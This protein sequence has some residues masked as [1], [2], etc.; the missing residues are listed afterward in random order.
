MNTD[1]SIR[2][3]HRGY[4]WWFFFSYFE[5]D[6]L[7]AFK[8]T[9]KAEANVAFSPFGNSYEDLLAKEGTNYNVLYTDYVNYS[10]IYTCNEAWFGTA[11]TELLWFMSRTNMIPE[12]DLTML[13]AK[14]TA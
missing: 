2:V 1:G 6:G 13:K 8:N 12:A 14:V 11:K 3:R 7:A 10:I 9:G 5:I 4:Y